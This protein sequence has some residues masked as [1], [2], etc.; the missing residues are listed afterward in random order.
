MKTR[1]IFI[2]T[3]VLL[4]MFVSCSGGKDNPAPTP[5]PAPPTVFVESVSLSKEW[6]D[7]MP[8]ESAQLTASVL[9]VNATNKVVFWTSTDNA[10]VS[11]NNGQVVANGPGTADI[12]LRSQDG[13]KEAVCNVMVSSPPS[14]DGLVRH[15]VVSQR[16]N[17]YNIVYLAEGYKE[18]ERERFDL[19]IENAVNWVFSTE[20]F[21]GYKE[22]FNVYSVFAISQDSG[23]ALYEG[24]KNTAFGS[25]L[26][27]NVMLNISKENRQLGYQYAL[28]ACKQ[29]HNIGFII[30]ES[31]GMYINSSTRAIFQDT[32]GQGAHHPY[33]DE[34]FYPIAFISGPGVGTMMHELAHNFKLADEYGP[35]SDSY[36]SGEAGVEIIKRTH[37]ADWIKD[38]GEV[39]WSYFIGRKG[40]ENVG[41]FP[42]C[43]G[44]HNLCRPTL[45]SVMSDP[46]IKYLNA[47][48]REGVVKELFKVVGETYTFE[49]F[50]ERDVP[51][52]Y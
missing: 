25:Y 46:R 43:N 47:P 20:P 28:R 42:G 35:Y 1:L 14:V 32:E 5:P 19:N 13:E 12:V 17:T 15:L 2:A 50:L 44:Y 29:P 16:P 23:V 11:V 52:G 7:F 18:F 45:E 38:P 31:G 37:N 9:P 27:S 26:E 49:K 6:L 33:L 41:V 36:R 48:S 34:N 22:Y 30:N 40:Y 24:G 4:T 39:S 8:G 10:V 51:N 3:S 21:K